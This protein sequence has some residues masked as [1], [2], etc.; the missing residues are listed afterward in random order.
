MTAHNLLHHIVPTITQNVPEIHL[1]VLL[2]QTPAL[3]PLVWTLDIE[4][5][6]RLAQENLVRKLR[7]SV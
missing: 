2:G 4:R 3:L 5:H 6:L 7:V 1:Q